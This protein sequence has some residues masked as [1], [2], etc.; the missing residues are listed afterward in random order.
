MAKK[1]TTASLIRKHGYVTYV[2]GNHGRLSIERP[3]GGLFKPY[4]RVPR[5]LFRRAT[6]ANVRRWSGINKRRR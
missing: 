3:E 2:P 5:N 6:I 1:E 4:D